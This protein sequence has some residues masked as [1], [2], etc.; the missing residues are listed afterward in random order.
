MSQSFT[1]A[2]RAGNSL[3]AD[4]YGADF[5][6]RPCIIYVHGFKGFKDWGFVPYAGQY[7]ADHGFSF[8]AF[9]FS[10]NGIGSDPLEF[11]EIDKF[12]KNTYSLEVSEIREVI[13]ACTQ[14]DVFG[15]RLHKKLGLLGH[16]RG[17]GMSIL[18]A[19][20]NP[21]VS[22]LATWASI[23]SVDRFPREEYGAWRK[24]G[25]RE[26]KNTRTG[27]IFRIGT[28]LLED[29]EKHGRSSLHILD[30]ARELGKPY[31]ILHG[32]RDETV[33]YY[34]GEQLNIFADPAFTEFRLVPGGD[35]T[36]GTRH[37][38]AGSTPQLDLALSQSLTFFEHHL[39]P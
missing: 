2:T 29:I 27:Q 6:Q 18:A 31:L 34:E 17:G 1:L 28:A 15:A 13:Q 8:I 20:Q 25:Y 24:Q 33:P 10:H 23:S 21:E 7:F 32:E 35:H 12:E 26:V 9:N 36:F 11:T 16:S 30:A 3:A 4:C 39:R 22:A 14:R 37:P 5:G 19:R 38:F